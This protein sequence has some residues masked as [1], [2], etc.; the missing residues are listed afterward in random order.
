MLAARGRLA[1]RPPWGAS[2]GSRSIPWRTSWRANRLAIDGSQ[3]SYSDTAPELRVHQLANGASAG[4]TK[5]DP[6]FVSVRIYA[7]L[8]LARAYD[9]SLLGARVGYITPK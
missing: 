6:D 2:D 4:L 1:I 7:K 9:E 8:L 3:V 5:E